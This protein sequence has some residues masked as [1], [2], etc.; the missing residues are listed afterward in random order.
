MLLCREMPMAAVA[1]TL[2]EHEHGSGAWRP[3]MSKGPTLR[4]RG[5]R[6]E[7]Q[8]HEPCLDGISRIQPPY[9]AAQRQHQRPAHCEDRAK[10]ST[11]SA[12]KASTRTPV[13]GSNGAEGSILRK[14]K[15]RQKDAERFPFIWSHPHFVMAV[16]AQFLYVAAHAGI[17]SF[18]I[19]YMT[20]EVPA[21]PAS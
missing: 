1:D 8:D 5:R 17:F 13:L 14:V 7:R 6:C 4:T 15:T 9:A 20:S 21:I 3:I 19:N 11:G 16:A 10:Y 2:G 12:R 18:F